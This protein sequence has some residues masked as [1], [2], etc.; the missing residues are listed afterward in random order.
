MNKQTVFVKCSPDE[1]EFSIEK[2]KEYSSLIPAKEL[3]DFYV[4]SEEEYLKLNKISDIINKLDNGI[5]VR[6]KHVKHLI[7]DILK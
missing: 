7:D 5:D 6:I 4:L 2:F 3:K 1:A